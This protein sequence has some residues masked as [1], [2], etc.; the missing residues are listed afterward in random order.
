METILVGLDE[1]PTGGAL[2]QWAAN[3][4]RLVG[5]ELL[6]V[7]AYQPSQSEFPP[8]WYE[9]EVAGLRKQAGALLDDITP[10]VPHRIEIRDGDART[11]IN[12]VA[13]EQGATMVVV[14]AR[15]GGGFLKLGLG[16]VAHQLEHALMTPLVIVPAV[17]SPLRG[18]PV[19]VGVDG[20]PEDLDVLDWAVRFAEAADGRVLAVYA[21]DPM[22]MTYPHPHG[23]TIA[24]QKEAIVRDQ[25]AAVARETG[26]SV[27]TVVDVDY[28]VMALTRTANEHDASLVVV[29]RKRARHLRG[30]LIGRVPAQLP[31]HAHRP[32]A[33]IPIAAAR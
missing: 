6:G 16:T 14:G 9:E 19:V 13:R 32:V 25:V 26:A 30:M 24:D 10:P 20:S 27:Q 31:F 1:P 15:R 7:V 4:C 28:P 3:Y 21:S 5:G 29:G 12:N 8:D 33:I 22:A 18:S 11:V 2:L 17:V 23:A